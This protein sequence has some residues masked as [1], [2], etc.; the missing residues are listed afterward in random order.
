MNQKRMIGLAAVLLSVCIVATACAPTVYE[1]YELQPNEYLMGED[2]SSVATYTPDGSTAQLTKDDIQA[3]NNGSAHMVFGNKGYLSFLNGKYY[4]GK[5][6][7]YEDAVASIQG[8]AELLGLGAGC[9]FFAKYGERDDDGYTYYVFQQRQ[10]DA[11]VP[12]ATLRVIVNPEG[13]TAGLSCSFTPNMGIVEIENPIS[14]EQAEQILQAEM[15]EKGLE[16]TYYSEC[17]TKVALTY[18]DM[19]VNCY[20]VYTNNPDMSTSF[21]MPYYEHF[22]T[23]GGKRLYSLPVASLNTDN[24][25]PYKAYEY[26]DGLEPMTYAGDVLLYDGSIRHIEVPIAYNPKDGLYYL[27]DVTRKIMVADYYAFEYQYE[28]LD[29][30]SSP[31]GKTWDNMHLITYANYITAYDFYNARGIQSIDGFG[32]PVLLC[33]NYCDKNRMPIDNC[34]HFGVNSGW[35]C[36]AA[37][38]EGY[39]H[40]E[41]LDIIVHEFTHGVTQYSMG[42]IYYMNDTGAI[43]EAYSDIMGNITEMLTGYTKDQSWLIGE[44]RGEPWRSMSAPNDYGQPE[45]KSDPLFF[46]PTDKPDHNTNDNGGVHYNSSLLNSVAYKLWKGG[47]PLEQEASLWVTSIELITPFSSY[48]EIHAALLMSVDINGFDQSYKTL[49]T[50]AFNDAELLG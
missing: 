4:E 37:S 5:I 28:T 50:D 23:Y 21:D 38:T 26:F 42:G 48:N 11:T 33:V 7:N 14:A 16:F 39:N 18:K 31:D 8:V 22:I 34:C 40:S 24:M 46:P 3:I 20:A 2:G 47:M 10:G 44:M 35:A 17:T 41:G 9:E 45:S 29:F 15:M 49:I 13:Y 6:T 43:N 25:D 12:Y 32:V 30:I 36:F 19:N 1:A 27:G